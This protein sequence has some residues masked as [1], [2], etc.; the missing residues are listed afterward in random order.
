MDLVDIAKAYGM[1]SVDKALFPRYGLHEVR[2]GYQMS[3]T[4]GAIGRKRG[5]KPVYG[6]KFTSQGSGGVPGWQADQQKRALNASRRG[7]ARPTS[8]EAEH[9]IRNRP[10]QPYDWMR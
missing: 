2:G 7:A 4:P 8:A 9:A 10:P 5:L 1:S 3:R 6:Q